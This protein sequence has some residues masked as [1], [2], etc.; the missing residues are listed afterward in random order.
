MHWILMYFC[1]VKIMSVV[2]SS[3]LR[4]EI[5]K[6]IVLNI[7][8][9]RKTMYGYEIT[10]VAKDMMNGEMQITEGAL[11][12]VLHQ[13]EYEGVLKTRKDHIR[14]RVQ[15]YYTLN[16]RTRKKTSEKI[17]TTKAYINTI[18]FFLTTKTVIA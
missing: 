14:G 9:G 10:E 1:V 2:R 3:E 16:T 4:R 17:N 5:F 18:I 12:P 6:T 11:Y 13:M 7:L 8:S 15:K